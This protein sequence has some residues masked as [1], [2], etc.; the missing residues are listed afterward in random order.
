MGFAVLDDLHKH[1]VLIVGPLT[2]ASVRLPLGITVAPQK[3]STMF[4]VTLTPLL[5]TR[6]S[7]VCVVGPV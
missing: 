3:I 5:F 7:R 2:G 6:R 1:V 4:V